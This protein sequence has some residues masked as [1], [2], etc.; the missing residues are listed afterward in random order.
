MFTLL[1]DFF[2]WEIQRSYHFFGNDEVDTFFRFWNFFFFTKNTNWSHTFV[3]IWGRRWDSRT[4]E[5]H[6]ALQSNTHPSVSH[7]NIPRHFAT[8]FTLFF[9]CVRLYI[10]KWTWHN[11]LISGDCKPPVSYCEQLYLLWRVATV[12]AVF[13]SLT[14][15]KW[16]NLLP[17]T[18]S[19][20]ISPLKFCSNIPLTFWPLTAEQRSFKLLRLA[21]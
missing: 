12:R 15:K 19:W 3:F 1:I 7:K 5:N 9:F 21:R 14:A 16:M 20:N 18:T 4:P 10:C 17:L 2:H 13:C 8:H 11:G 6:F